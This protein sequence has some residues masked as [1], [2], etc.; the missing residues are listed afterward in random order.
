MRGM[1][2]EQLF[3]IFLMVAMVLILAVWL[4]MGNNVDFLS[5]VK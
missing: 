3:F 4:L 2:W 1:E 5:Y